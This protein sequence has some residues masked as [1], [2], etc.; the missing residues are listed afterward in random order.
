MSYYE[1]KKTGMFK[2]NSRPK[3]F[4]AVVSHYKKRLE[5]ISKNKELLLI[6]LCVL[7]S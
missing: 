2:E 3:N 7:V 1:D 4:I 6:V 5:N